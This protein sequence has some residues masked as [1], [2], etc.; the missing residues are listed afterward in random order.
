MKKSII[1]LHTMEDEHF[2]ITIVEMMVFIIFAN[3]KK[4]KR[5]QIIYLLKKI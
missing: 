1:G 4:R 2:G 5:F 3:I